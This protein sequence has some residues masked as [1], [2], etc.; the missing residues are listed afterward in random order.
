MHRLDRGR[1]PRKPVCPSGSRGVADTV[2]CVPCRS[3]TTVTVCPGMSEDPACTSSHGRRGLPSML[4]TV[5][6]ACRPAAAAGVPASTVSM[7]R[8]RHLVALQA[9]D[10]QQHERHDDVHGDAGDDEDDSCQN[11]WA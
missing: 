10:E 7:V 2:T 3:T 6:P 11:G 4:T 5:S 1:T 8:G 9:D